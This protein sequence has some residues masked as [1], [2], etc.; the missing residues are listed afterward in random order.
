MSLIY[1]WFLFTNGSYLSVALISGTYLSVALSQYYSIYL[2][3]YWGKRA[4]L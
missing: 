2:V 3:Y 1:Q 4:G